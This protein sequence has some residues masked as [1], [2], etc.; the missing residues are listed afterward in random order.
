MFLQGVNMYDIYRGTLVT[1]DDVVR[2]EQ[3]SLADLVPM[4]S[5]YDALRLAAANNPDKPAVKHLKS[6]FDCDPETIDFKT[7]L[8]LVEKAA[9]LF[10]SASFAEPAVVAVVGPFITEVLISMWAGSVAGRYV[11]INPFLTTENI[12]EILNAAKATVLVTAYTSFSATQED[13]LDNIKAAVPTLKKIYLIGD[14]NS[15]E[16]R[17]NTVLSN[18]VSSGLN[19]YPVAANDGECAYMHTGGTTGTPKLVRHTQRG[20]LIQAWLCGMT[21]APGKNDVIGH[22]MPTFH[23]GGAITN[24]LRGIVF[25]QTVVT[26]TQDGFRTPGLLAEFW[27]IVDYFGITSVTATPTTAVALLN[28]GE[29][30]TTKLRN[31]IAAG[32]PLAREV[33]NAFHEKFGI[34]LREAWGGTEFQGL[35]SFHYNGN[36]EP[37]IGSCGRV[38]PFH[39]VISA[40]L[41][42]N[43]FV[44]LAKDDER[45]I[46]I[47]TGPT[48]IPGFVDSAQ[49]DKF[50]VENGPE[51]LRWAT[52]GDVG[53]VDED[54]FVWIYGREK[55]VIIRGGHNIDSAKIDEV[56][57]SHP[58]VALAAAVAKPDI[59]KGE[60]PMAYVELISGTQ[61]TPEEIMEFAREQMTERAAV[62]V[63]IVIL[64]KLPLTAVGKLSKPPLRLDAIR[65]EIVRQCNHHIPDSKVEVHIYEKNGKISSVVNI[66][67]INDDNFIKIKEVLSL[68]TLDI[69]IKKV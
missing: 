53:S 38:V 33:A 67:N 54:Q 29:K 12:T 37:R 11:P 35:L 63:E 19:F 39:K 3:R 24:G 4:N 50:F 69:L 10:Y 26:L 34:W 16:E 30:R 56:L 62:P 36:V 28:C 51:G 68:Y 8:E 40:I 65:R 45:G 49:D 9:N 55:D 20:Q 32:A 14:A 21:M 43:R 27:N 59:E 47:A 52:T 60:L 2:L 15:K 31:F 61:A 6:P 66:E 44:R 5:I 42:G 58:A 23:L 18:K 1:N 25:G 22:A 57:M 41:E 48:T 46:L 13:E 7:Y 64:D 17:L